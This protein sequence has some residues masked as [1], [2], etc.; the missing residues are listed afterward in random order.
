MKIL[1]VSP[2]PPPAGGIATWTEKYLSYCKNNKHNKLGSQENEKIITISNITNIKYDDLL[3]YFK[4]Y[5]ILYKN[6]KLSTIECNETN[7][8]AF[9]LQYDM[10]KEPIISYF[11]I[12]KNKTTEKCDINNYYKTNENLH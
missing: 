6:I 3:K 1:L 2:L 7:I 11:I 10:N 4:N 8:K 9:G 5:T 12:T